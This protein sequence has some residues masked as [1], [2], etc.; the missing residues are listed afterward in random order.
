MRTW[1]KRGRRGW[2]SVVSN[3]LG[4]GGGRWAVEEEEAAVGTVGL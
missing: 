4:C 1:R 2:W 3:G